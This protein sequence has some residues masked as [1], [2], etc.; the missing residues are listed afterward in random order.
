MFDKLTS[1]GPGRVLLQNIDPDVFGD[2]L[3]LLEGSPLLQEYEPSICEALQRY[4]HQRNFRA[5]GIF[6][7]I[8][9]QLAELHE[10]DAILVDVSPS[11]SAINQVSFAADSGLARSCGRANA[12]LAP[13]RRLLLSICCRL[14]VYFSLGHV[15]SGSQS[16]FHCI[17]PRLLA[18]DF[19]RVVPLWPHTR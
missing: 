6:A 18:G 15:T 8:M 5:Y 7:Y 2:K 17:L 14:H 10:L 16:G 13:C 1:V 4:E 19:G 3:W 12:L 9:T 11:N